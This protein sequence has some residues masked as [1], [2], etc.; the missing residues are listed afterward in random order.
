MALCQ[1]EGS[2]K[3]PALEDHAKRESKVSVRV[4]T[5]CVPQRQITSCPY[6][7]TLP[8]LSG[9]PLYCYCRCYQ[10]HYCYGYASLRTNGTHVL[11]CLTHKWNTRTRMSYTQMEHT[12][13]N[14]LQTNG[15]HVL[16]CLTHNWNTVAVC[17]TH[18]RKTR[19]SMPYTQTEHTY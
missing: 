17:L 15:T 7:L 19:T 18:K 5:A 16:V 13:Q 8:T 9:S 4:N 3:L 1:Q 2:E 10:Y 11:E 12:Y 14:A 6:R